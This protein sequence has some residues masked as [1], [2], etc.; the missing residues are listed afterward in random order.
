[1][2]DAQTPIKKRG[3]PRKDATEAPAVVAGPPKIGAVIPRT[4][5]GTW[6]ADDVLAKR[7]AGQPFGIKAASI[8]LAEPHKWQ[9]YIANSGADDGRHYDMVFRKGWVPVTAADLAPGVQPESLGLR[10]NE[11]GAL[12][13]GARGDEIV[14]KMPKGAYDTLQR[15]KA[16]KNVEG[17][18]SKAKSRMAV[19][20]AA[21]SEL[22]DEAAEFL[23]KHAV[24][25]V[26][27]SQRT[28]V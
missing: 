3:R 11:S 17:I 14:Y 21:A 9:L 16:E 25:D 23:S 13:R 2:S 1:M 19:A 5:E 27:D 28:E 4:E 18:G 15:Q 8:P 6:S 26:Q 7:L 12:C 24:I 10:V 20:E 22:G